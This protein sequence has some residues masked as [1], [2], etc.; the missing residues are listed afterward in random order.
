MA[1]TLSTMLPLGTSMPPFSLTDA[2]SGRTITDRDV[3]GP[4]G[5]IVMFLC[6]HCPFVKHVL[7]ELDRLAA[8]YAGKGIGVVAINSND[9]VAYPQD[10]PGPMKELATSR[11]WKFPFLID[12]EQSVGRAHH[13]A[14]TPDF[15]V[16]DAERRLAY[17]GRLDESRPNSAVPLTGADLRAALDAILAG[18]A[19]AADQKPSVGCGIKWK[20]GVIPGSEIR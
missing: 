4:K 9:V 17:R 20:A 13:A 1:E 3:A 8:E 5:T 7:P 6:N 2:V 16:F 15:F 19:P 14:C 11:G 10:G 18:R 12:E